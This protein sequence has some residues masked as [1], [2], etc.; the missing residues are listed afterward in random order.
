MLRVVPVAQLLRV[1]GTAFDAPVWRGMRDPLC[2]S[3]VELALTEN[4]LYDP[5]HGECDSSKGLWS[6]KRHAE[7]VA[8]FV[9][10]GWDDPIQLNTGALWPV[11]DGNHRLAAA[12]Y[13]R[14]AAIR[15]QLVAPTATRRA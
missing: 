6:P 12:V 9:R 5:A 8:W 1:V 2:P 11:V 14:D 10:H 3:A 15:V 4:R 7:R 13:R